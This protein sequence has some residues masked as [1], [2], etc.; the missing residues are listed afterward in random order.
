M[1]TSNATKLNPALTDPL[2]TG[3]VKAKAEGCALTG[4]RERLDC[5]AKDYKKGR[6]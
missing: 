3:T 1:T 4:W 5:L 2:S 6:T